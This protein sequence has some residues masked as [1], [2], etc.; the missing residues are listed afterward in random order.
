MSHKVVYSSFKGGVLYQ[1][2]T[3]LNLCYRKLYAFLDSLVAVQNIKSFPY[4]KHWVTNR[5]IGRR[6]IFESIML[7]VFSWTIIFWPVDIS[8]SDQAIHYFIFNKLLIRP[9]CF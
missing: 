9:A 1:Q 4:L 3:E 5:I 2:L 6:L 7:T 8:Y